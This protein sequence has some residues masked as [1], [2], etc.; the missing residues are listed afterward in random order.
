MKAGNIERRA[1]ILLTAIVAFAVNLLA[2]Q[3]YKAIVVKEGGTISGVVRLQGS[4]PKLDFDITKDNDWCGTKKKSPRLVVGKNNGVAN[5]VISLVG[6]AEGKKHLYG[7]KYILDQRKCEYVPHVLLL[8]MGSPLEIVNSDAVL[9]NV[10]TYEGSGRTIFNI[11]Q[12][13]KG[14]RFP[15]KAS[16]FAMPGAYHATCD[17]G[18]PWMSAYVIATEHPYYVLSNPVGKFELR[19]V[20]PGTY[21]LKMWHEGVNVTRTE[22]DGKK[23]KVYYYEPPYEKIREVVVQRNGNISVDFMLELRPAAIVKN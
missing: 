12:P 8:P 11:A 2:A 9:H 13:I 14:V 23:A 20:P 22:L 3:P 7:G 4:L 17:A 21:K 5:A 19:D 10:H 15:V 18:H 16:Q 1:S 6:I